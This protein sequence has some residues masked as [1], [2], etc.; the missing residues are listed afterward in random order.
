MISHQQAYDAIHMRYLCLTILS[1][2]PL[3]FPLMG[4]EV[5]AID[6][7]G[8]GLSS[9]PWQHP[10]HPGEKVHGPGADAMARAQ[11]AAQHGTVRTTLV[12]TDRLEYHVWQSI[13]YEVRIE[14]IGANPIR[15]PI[16][17]DRGALQPEGSAAPFD[18][19]QMTLSLDA[20]T[21][22]TRAMLDFQLFYGSDTKPDT[23]IALK[24]GEWLTIRA[25]SEI[26]PPPR[27][28]YD[29]LSEIHAINA[30]VQLSSNHVDPTTGAE[31]GWGG[32]VR[33]VEGP[34]RPIRITPQVI[35]YN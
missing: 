35:N 5:K 28:I 17:R 30:E 24:P 15:I 18:Y 29:E 20:K 9:A 8:H 22:R 14:N 16:G 13:A 4:Q 1:L 19:W 23:M 7:T 6:V 2:L 27:P 34:D 31:T 3:S 10:L 11:A 21:S 32:W 26:Q 12:R 25:K 33:N